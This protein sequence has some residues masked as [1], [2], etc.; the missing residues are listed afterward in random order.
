LF[1]CKDLNE[2]DAASS[3]VFVPTEIH[4][5]RYVRF[6]YTPVSQFG[7]VGLFTLLSLYKNNKLLGETVHAY[8]TVA[9]A[10][11][12]PSIQNLHIQRKKSRDL[13]KSADE[14]LFFF[15]VFLI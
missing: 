1:L 4:S 3:L 12:P 9:V 10:P 2:P 11:G 7:I 14:R 8:S 5:F 6:S 15:F 13:R